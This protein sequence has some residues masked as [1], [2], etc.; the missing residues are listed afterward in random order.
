MAEADYMALER[1]ELINT[2]VDD[3]RGWQDDALNLP[4]ERKVINV[5]TD[6]YYS[7]ILNSEVPWIIAFVKKVKAQDH[8]VHS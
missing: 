5:T 7:Q 3:F 6:I 4:D 1:L 2:F 8:L